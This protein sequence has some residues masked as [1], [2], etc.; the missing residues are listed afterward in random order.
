M[1]TSQVFHLLKLGP[2]LSKLDFYWDSLW[3]KFCWV[4]M[5][6]VER[7][8]LYRNVSKPSSYLMSPPRLSQWISRRHKRPGFDPWVRNIP[9]RRAWQPTPI[10]G[11]RS[12]VGYSP[13]SHKESDT[14]DRLHAHVH[15]HTQIAKNSAKNHLTVGVS[16][17]PS[18]P[19]CLLA[20]GGRMF[21]L[22]FNK[23]GLFCIK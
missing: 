2:S 1:E 13:W 19:D 22:F 15:T 4:L 12:L 3:W 16:G 11:Q 23:H 9:R 5:D 18:I 14:T 20:P 10:Y 17:D 6:D 21:Y 7:W 8:Y